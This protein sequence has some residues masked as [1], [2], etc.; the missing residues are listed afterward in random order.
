VRGLAAL[1][2]TGVIL[3]AIYLLYMFQKV[4]FGKLDKEKNGNLPDLK[5]H[6]LATFIPLVLA[7][8]AGGLFP[9]TI[10][11]TMQPSVNHF[12]SEF[13]KHV[14]SPD[15][16][17]AYTYA[18]GCK[19]RAPDATIATPPAAAPAPEEAAQ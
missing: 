12:V 10:L 3:G 14:D 4:F 19:A 17:F 7:I 11:K 6:E 1:A 2:A 16:A 8:L 5:G 9:Q 15:C 18:N 13:Q